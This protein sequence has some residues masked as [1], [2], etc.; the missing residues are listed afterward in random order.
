MK[1]FLEKIVSAI[2]DDPLS[3][4]ILEKPEEGLTVL[5]IIAPEG[6]VGKIIGKG[7]RVINAIR[8]LCRLKGGKNL[9]RFLIRV[10]AKAA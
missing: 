10:E 8:A 7:G 5:T 1:D 9:S 2:V 3:V 6:E 4:E